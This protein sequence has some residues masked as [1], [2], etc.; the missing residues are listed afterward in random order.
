MFPMPKKALRVYC[1]NPFVS[2]GEL[3]SRS[4]SRLDVT[5]SR[6]LFQLFCQFVR[7]S[8]VFVITVFVMFS[9]TQQYIFL[10]FLQLDCRNMAIFLFVLVLF[11]SDVRPVA[12]GLHTPGRVAADTVTSARAGWDSLD[13]DSRV[14]GVCQHHQAYPCLRYTRDELLSFDGQYVCSAQ[15]AERVHQLGLALG[16]HRC[17]RPTRKRPY[18]A[19]R[20][21]QG[22]TIPVIISDRPTSQ[23]RTLRPL[24]TPT[25]DSARRLSFE[26]DTNSDSTICYSN[27]IKIDTSLFTQELSRHFK[28]MFLN[29]QSVRNKTTDICDNVMHANVDLSKKFSV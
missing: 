24:T 20:H 8:V 25:F 12:N 28:V 5:R 4:P 2:L 9:P 19:G 11:L 18:R 3:C 1:W 17:R 26:C 13:H 15:L 21:K 29:T 10:N 23:P 27:L 14:P 6:L 16:G 22:R 7:Y